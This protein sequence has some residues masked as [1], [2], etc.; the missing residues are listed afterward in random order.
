M[1][2]SGGCGRRSATLTCSLRT[3]LPSAGAFCGSCE[4]TAKGSFSGQSCVTGQCSELV[5]SLGFAGTAGQCARWRLHGGRH[6]VAGESSCFWVKSN[7]ATL[8]VAITRAKRCPQRPGNQNHQAR[9][10]N[11][12]S[13]CSCHQVFHFENGLRLESPFVNASPKLGQRLSFV[14]WQTKSR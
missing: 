4:L 6:T 14:Q 10:Q 5:K 11:R 9:R 12:V 8:F 2:L 3:P 7:M 1:P 13:F